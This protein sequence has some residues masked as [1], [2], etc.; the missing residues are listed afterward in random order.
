MRTQLHAMIWEVWRTSRS[1]LLLRTAGM[2]GFVLLICGTTAAKTFNEPETRVLCGMALMVLTFGSV[3]TQNWIYQLDRQQTGFSFRLGFVRPVSTT[4]LVAV[5][6]MF[7]TAAAVISYLLSMTLFS[8][9][10]NVS[11][12]LVGPAAVI[13]CAVVCCM[14]ATWSPTAI[15]AK[16]IGLTVL[17]AA[18]V[19]S[20]VAFHARHETPDP[21]L[22]AI[23]S[24]EYFDFGWQ[25]YA[26]LLI[27]AALAFVVTVAAVERQRHGD[28]FQLASLTRVGQ[29]FKLSYRR[30][31]RP[32]TSRFAA[33]CWYESQRFGRT[34]LLLGVLAPLIIF[35]FVSMAPRHDP[36][37]QA[38][39]YVWLGA[40]V[41]CPF[42]Y[43]L[44]G[45]D[46]ALGL[47][48]KQG[49]TQFSAFDATRAMPNDRLIASKLLVIAA[50]SLIGW[51]CMGLAAASHVV[52]FGD[53]D[54]WVRIGQAASRAVGDVPIYWWIA[55]VCC[56]VLQYISTTSILLACGAP[57]HGRLFV[58][59]IVL[60]YAHMMLAMWD[61]KHHWTLWYLWTAYGYL[62]SVRS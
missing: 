20:L 34:V 24:P 19:M 39:A 44:V 23:G 5:P 4:M 55:G 26:A 61:A 50:C 33:Q 9:L 25:H 62:L 38:V 53:W 42:V 60:V 35:V 16:V 21:I 57:L 56:V 27:L 12:P 13:A 51:L 22:I 58:C 41:L 18:M 54:L 49:A 30:R 8:L 47:R 29:V 52:L 36:N 46:G 15:F 17:A 7:T 59:L 48:Q 45:A 6:L 32:F 1:E 3:T 2:V 37:R 28:H 40:L 31:Q 43:Q 10:M 11:M 14:A